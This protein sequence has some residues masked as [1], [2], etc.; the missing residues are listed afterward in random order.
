MCSGALVWQH[1]I[2]CT[3]EESVDVHSL[4]KNIC[5]YTK[6]QQQNNEVVMHQVK[7]H[8]YRY[9]TLFCGDNLPLLQEIEKYH[10]EK[11][12]LFYRPKNV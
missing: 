11:I 2:Q 8:P 10:M 9:N 12:P 6:L 4:R 3:R 1:N 5:G 7:L